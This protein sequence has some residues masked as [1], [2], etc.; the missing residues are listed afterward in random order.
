MP[1][2]RIVP[3][4]QEEPLVFGSPRPGYPSKTVAAPVVNSWI[5]AAKT[6]GI[7]RICCLLPPAQLQYYQVDLLAMY[8]D[9]FDPA[10]VC[11]AEIPDYHLC[12][13]ATL[14]RHILPFLHESA[15]AAMPVLVHCS[16]GTGRTGHVLAAWLVRHR[17]LTVDEALT[18]VKKTRRNPWEAIQCGYATEKELRCLLAGDH[19]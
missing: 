11:W 17:G 5:S 2:F 15:E 1:E 4:R 3:A 18:A 14:E 13:H 8:R 16:G 19:R 9:A 7:R 10:N 6:S 12:D